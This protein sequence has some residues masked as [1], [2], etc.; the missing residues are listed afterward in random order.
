MSIEYRPL[1]YADYDKHEANLTELLCDAVNNGASVNFV[2]PLSIGEAMQF[3][4]RIAGD[5]QQEKVV[6]IAAINAEKVIGSVMIV[7]AWQPNGLHRA[8]I[9]KMLVHSAYRRR[10]IATQLMQAAEETASQMGRWLLFLDTEYGSGAQ[11]FYEKLSYTQ[12]GIM[13]HHSRN[14]AGELS[15][16]VFFY[17]ILPH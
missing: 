7:P 13:P 1:P 8:E 11:P 14:S 5:L 3:W 12:M 16:T 10:G 17:K 2:A 15:D 6:L 9:Q 4:R